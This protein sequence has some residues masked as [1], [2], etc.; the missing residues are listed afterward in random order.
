MRE[1]RRTLFTKCWFIES[2]PN[3]FT[4]SFKQILLK[5]V[6]LIS[7]HH[8]PGRWAAISPLRAQVHVAERDTDATKRACRRAFVFMYACVCDYVWPCALVWLHVVNSVACLIRVYVFV[9]AGGCLQCLLQPHCVCVCA[10]QSWQLALLR[11]SVCIDI[12]VERVKLNSWYNCQ[13]IPVTTGCDVTMDTLL[14]T[15]S[16]KP[17]RH[18]AQGTLHVLCMAWYYIQ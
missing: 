5:G 1:Y 3:G 9:F 11:S 16:V 4:V 14:D 10:T 12:S 18:S 6:A 15:Q 2:T 7:R 13:Q 17:S 8:R